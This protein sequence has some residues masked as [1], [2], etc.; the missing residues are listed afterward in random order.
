MANQNMRSI[1]NLNLPLLFIFLLIISGCANQTTPTG[2][3]KDEVAPKL[4]SSDPENNEVNFTEKTITLRFNEY[5][6]EEKLKEQLIISPSIENPYTT[7]INK[8]QFELEFENQ[9]DSATTFTFNF[10]NGI[11][12]ITE[13]NPAEDLILT[14]STGAYIDSLNIQGSAY[15]LLTGAVKNDWIAGLYLPSDT[16]NPFNSK[17]R[18]FAKTDSAGNYSLRNLTA[19]VYE[20]YLW[21][22]KNSNLQINSF[23]EI[24]GYYPEQLN[25][26]QDLRG[27]R[28]PLLLNFSDSLQLVSARAIGPNFLIRMNKPF[29]SYSLTPNDTSKIIYSI[30]QQEDYS[31]KIYNISTKKKYIKLY[32]I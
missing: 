10:R 2:G 27:L 31:I 7:K 5:I 19:G 32:Y 23:D 24:Y 4:L 15:N 3:P 1:I 16:L 29:I 9:L 21:E 30:A 18:Y 22:D 11:Q 25:I 13:N 14:F 6:K 20:L 12:D 26:D 17:P 28:I 8:Q